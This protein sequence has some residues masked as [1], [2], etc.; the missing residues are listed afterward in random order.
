M[1]TGKMLPHLGCGKIKMPSSIKHVPYT[2]KEEE[3][4]EVERNKPLMVY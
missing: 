3:E 4:E 2:K 1:K